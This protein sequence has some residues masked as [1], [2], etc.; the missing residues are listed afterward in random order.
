MTSEKEYKTKEERGSTKCFKEKVD[1]NKVNKIFAKRWIIDNLQQHVPDDDIAVEFIYELLVGADQ[2]K[3]E[4]SVIRLYTDEILGKKESTQF[5]LA[6]WQWLL[7]AQKTKNGVPRELLEQRITAMNL[8][9]LKHPEFTE[10]NIAAGTITEFGAEPT[11][12]GILTNVD[13]EA[14]VEA[15]HILE[16]LRPKTK[17]RVN[18]RVEKPK[19]K[20]NYNRG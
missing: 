17:S 5:C 14:L 3:P 1:I 10:T 9:S 8:G 6:L 18:N 4:I 12:I 15:N 11:R 7:N 16:A 20:T 2:G 13:K 19:G